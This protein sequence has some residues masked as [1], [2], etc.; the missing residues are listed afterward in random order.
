MTLQGVAR[1]RSMDRQARAKARFTA[2]V[3]AQSVEAVESS[4]SVEAVVS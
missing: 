1:A 2:C 4:R 3:L